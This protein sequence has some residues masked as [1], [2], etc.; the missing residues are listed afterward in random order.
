[1]RRLGGVHVDARHAE[2]ARDPFLRSA[3]ERIKPLSDLD[4]LESDGREQRKELCLRQSATDSARPQ[5]DVAT[6]R[7]RELGGDHDVGVQEP[8][9][10]AKNPKHLGE[11]AALVG[12]EVQ[13]AI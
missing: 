7:F 5:V 1:M 2:L 3:E 6:D 12:R 10:W 4:A 13:H 9:A 8:S 11:S